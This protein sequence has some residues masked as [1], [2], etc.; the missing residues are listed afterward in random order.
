MR[1]LVPSKTLDTHLTPSEFVNTVSRRLGVDVMDSGMPCCFCG[2]H[3]DA[4]GS[5]CF[6]CRAGRDA[7]R[8]ISEAPNVLLDVFTLDGRCRPVDI[9]C[10]PALALARVLPNGARAVRTEPVCMDIAVINALGQDHWRHTA[11]R[12]GSAADVYSAAKATRNDISNKCWAEGYRFWPIVHEIQGGMAK[13]ENERRLAKFIQLWSCCCDVSTEEKVSQ[14]L[15]RRILVFPVPCP[16]FLTIRNFAG[17]PSARCQQQWRRVLC[18]VIVHFSC[19]F[20]WR[21][22]YCWSTG[23]FLHS[24][25][26]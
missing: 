4:Q 21:A 25:S 26:R 2:H 16:A 12:A 15:N 7:T 19:A 22:K 13:K 5:H 1:S 14:F 18:C 20:P 17:T 3:L 8:P 9:L 6:S 24:G 11:V 23:A 10:I